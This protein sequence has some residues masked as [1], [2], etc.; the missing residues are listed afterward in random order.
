MFSG[1]VAA[2]QICD[3]AL[4]HCHGGLSLKAQCIEFQLS[5]CEQIFLEV[6]ILSSVLCC[7]V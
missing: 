3:I 7:Y 6:V 5:Y 4:M 1:P 2:R